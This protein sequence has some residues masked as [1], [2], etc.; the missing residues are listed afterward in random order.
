MN[1]FEIIFIKPKT[2]VI[3]ARPKTMRSTISE[4][5]KNVQKREIQSKTKN[6]STH[7]LCAQYDMRKC[8]LQCLNGYRVEHRKERSGG[9]DIPMRQTRK[10]STQKMDQI[11]RH[12]GTHCVFFFPLGD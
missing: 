11:G 4:D 2:A 5:F 3:I 7:V 6:V 1:V 9:S 8:R 12:Q 10:N